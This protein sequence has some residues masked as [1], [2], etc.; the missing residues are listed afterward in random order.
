MHGL[1]VSFRAFPKFKK[2]ATLSLITREFVRFL[3]YIVE[4]LII[5]GERERAC[6][7]MGDFNIDFMIDSF[8]TRKLQTTMQ[9]LGMKQ[10]VNRPTIITKDSQTIIELFFANN[11]V[12][13]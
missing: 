1:A 11:R 8:Y 7:V 13:V 10:Y 6:M 2:G 12:Q 5:K 4:E 3:V 9:S